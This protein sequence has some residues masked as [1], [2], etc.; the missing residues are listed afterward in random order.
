MPPFGSED[1]LDT[2]VALKPYAVDAKWEILS[3]SLIDRLHGAGIK[4]FSGTL[5]RNERVEEYR[6]VIAWGIDVIQTDHPLRVL[7][8]IE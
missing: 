6:K 3:K 7:R 2:L 4:V 5:G 8:A 1:E